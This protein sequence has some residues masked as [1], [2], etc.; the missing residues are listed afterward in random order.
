MR[1]NLQRLLREENVIEELKS[2]EVS[3]MTPKTFY[4]F[5]D[6]DP[7]AQFDSIH[8]EFLL[9]DANIHLYL[10]TKCLKNDLILKN[11][12]ADEI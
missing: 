3:L 9:K 4:K 6:K 7:E 12:M 2:Y 5:T 11:E 8:K 10:R 1:D